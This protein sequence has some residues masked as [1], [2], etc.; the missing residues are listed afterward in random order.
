M[1]FS[2]NGSEL[3]D[4][5]TT[6]APISGSFLLFQV[7][8]GRLLITARSAQTEVTIDLSVLSDLDGI[9]A[10]PEQQITAIS[11]H[12]GRLHIEVDHDFVMTVTTDL[13]VR[14]MIQCQIKDVIVR[15]PQ[16]QKDSCV[17][18]SIRSLCDALQTSA[19]AALLNTEY[20]PMSAW[21]G[22]CFYLEGSNV[23]ASDGF[24][25][26]IV[27]FDGFIPGNGLIVHRETANM[28][29]EHGY[30]WVAIE[31]EHDCSMKIYFSSET[32][33]FVLGNTTIIGVLLPNE[34]PLDAIERAIV[35]PPG[36]TRISCDLG[37]LVRA[38]DL[39]AA[40]EP[41]YVNINV[42]SDS[43]RLT[44][45]TKGNYGKLIDSCE[46]SIKAEIHGPISAS[47]SI[48]CQYLLAVLK[49]IS[50]PT[51]DIEIPLAGR[52]PITIDGHHAKFAIMPINARR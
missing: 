45:I 5:I 13:S 35:A 22:S 3:H 8:D 39:V 42:E 10:I 6:I 52:I 7:N 28:V 19:T 29:A 47:T 2:I 49:S 43:I 25:L 12:G 11:S 9:A 44:G 23:Y 18:S 24:R 46:L 32:V 16:D 50:Y 26:A 36:S 27:P 20:M 21:L 31:R 51:V 30:K 38:I 40:I 14:Y 4:A 1:K 48:N 33:K 37:A 41:D 15:L 17:I 34:Y